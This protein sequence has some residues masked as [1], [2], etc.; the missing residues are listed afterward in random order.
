[1]KQCFVGDGTNNNCNHETS[2][3]ND[4]NNNNSHNEDNGFS[5]SISRAQRTYE[6]VSLLSTER[7]RVK[8]DPRRTGETIFG[9]IRLNGRAIEPPGGGGCWTRDYENLVPTSSELSLY[10]NNNRG[11]SSNGGSGH[12]SLRRNGHLPNSCRVIENKLAISNDD[13]LEAIQQLSM[14]AT[15][16]KETI[17]ATPKLNNTERNNARSNEAKA[18][19]ERERLQERDRNKYVEFLHNEKLH[20]L[21]NM[22]VLKRSIADIEVQEEEIN[23]EVRN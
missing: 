5:A 16:S 20:I 12:S 14:L 19:R 1:M 11:C 2:T 9:T 10:E 21:G 18:D 13:L 23:R 7:E 8:V 3:N 15:R 4:D 22:D 6:N 17:V